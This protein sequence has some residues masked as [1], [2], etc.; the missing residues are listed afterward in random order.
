MVDGVGYTHAQGSHTLRHTYTENQ[1]SL[2][3]Q[4]Q[5]NWAH[6]TQFQLGNRNNTK[7]DF[8]VLNQHTDTARQ[9]IIAEWIISFSIQQNPIKKRLVLCRESREKPTRPIPIWQ[10]A[11]RV[12][13]FDRKPTQYGRTTT[14]LPTLMKFAHL[15]FCIIILFISFRFFLS[16]F[17]NQPHKKKQGLF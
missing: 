5:T 3:W 10:W 1:Y 2:R 6:T 9:I 17:R 7:Q 11:T 16:K 12:V 15:F 14:T 13:S 8:F 4:R